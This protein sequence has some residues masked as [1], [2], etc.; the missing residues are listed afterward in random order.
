MTA[1]QKIENLLNAVADAGYKQ[2]DHYIVVSADLEREWLTELLTEKNPMD[3]LPCRVYVCHGMK[4]V[5]VVHGDFLAGFIDHVIA[6][7]R[8]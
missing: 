3:P 7:S 6:L 8:K 5:A 1:R 4:G 2:E